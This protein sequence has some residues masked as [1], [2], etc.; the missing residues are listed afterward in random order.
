MGG[1]TLF[2]YFLL[3][4]YS[5]FGR[6]GSLLLC[7]GLLSCRS[8]V[9]ATF[10]V[11]VAS[12]GRTQTLGSSGF[13]SCSHG[14]SSCGARVQ[15]LC[16]LMRSSRTRDQTQVSCIGR[17]IL[18]Y[19]AT[20]EVLTSSFCL[21]P[22]TWMRA[23]ALGSM[24][25]L[26]VDWL[27]ALVKDGSC[28]N[29]YKRAFRLHFSRSSCLWPEHRKWISRKRRKLSFQVHQIP[30]LFIR[31]T[32]PAGE[33]LGRLRN[34]FVPMAASCPVGGEGVQE[35]SWFK[36]GSWLSTWA[37]CCHWQFRSPFK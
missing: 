22:V 4:I 32:G 16:V 5:A 29:S 13:S 17:Q 25:E 15:L 3:L 9:M 31:P 36:A 19:W 23:R 10:L 11:P 6:A 7:V 21:S 28:R 27:T 37:V 26:W 30:G 33:L 18:I 14:L 2:L 24:S 20:R 35:G 34:L 1:S 12:R 8:G